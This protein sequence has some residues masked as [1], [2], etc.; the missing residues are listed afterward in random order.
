[1]FKLLSI[2]D[3]HS[4]VWSYW[5]IVSTDTTNREQVNLCFAYITGKLLQ[6]FLCL[7]AEESS[8]L[9]YSHFKAYFSCITISF[10]PT[11]VLVIALLVFYDH[12][13]NYLGASRSLVQLSLLC[14]LSY[15]ET[16]SSPSS[17]LAIYTETQTKE[18]RD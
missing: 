16:P 10:P 2:I 18:A 13:L 8:I 14:Q 9:S 4:F 11:Q 1:M 6:H 15:R 3:L 17:G 12:K 7:T 5:K